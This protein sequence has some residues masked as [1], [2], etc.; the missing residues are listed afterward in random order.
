MPS[1]ASRP[2]NRLADNAFHLQPG[3]PAGRYAPCRPNV[4]DLRDGVGG[5]PALAA[6]HHHGAV[7]GS[8]RRE[9]T[10]GRPVMTVPIPYT[11]SRSDAAARCGRRA[12][13]SDLEVRRRVIGPAVMATC[14]PRAGDRSAAR[15]FAPPVERS[16][17][18]GIQRPPGHQFLGGLEDQPAPPSAVPAPRRRARRRLPAPSPWGVVPTGVRHPH[19]R[20]V[21]RSGSLHRQR[22]P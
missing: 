15:K 12:S 16:G 14:R 6:P 2:G 8:I 9:S 19:R 7:P 4:P 20:G 18:D 13:A 10:P 1:G 17:G 21:G 5:Y 11:R 3:F 22:G